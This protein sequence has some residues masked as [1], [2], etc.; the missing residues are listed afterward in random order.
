[1]I[2]LNPVRVFE[3]GLGRTPDP[4]TAAAREPSDGPWLLWPVD[5][6]VRIHQHFQT[7]CWDIQERKDFEDEVMKETAA[8]VQPTLHFVFFGFGLTSSP[9]KSFDTGHIR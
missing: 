6:S 1:M 9:E 2:H 5:G 7:L 8:N 4:A 3:T